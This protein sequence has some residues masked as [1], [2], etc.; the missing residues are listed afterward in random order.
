[1][2][3]SRPGVGL[4]VG[5]DLHSRAGVGL[6][7]GAALHSRAGVGLHAGADRHSRVPVALRAA[8]DWLPHGL[9]KKMFARFE[10]RAYGRVWILGAHSSAPLHPQVLPEGVCPMSRTRPNN[11]AE[12]ATCIA[13]LAPLIGDLSQPAPLSALLEFDF[14]PC[15]DGFLA[16]SKRK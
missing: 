2:A 1:G 4:R 6:R 3:H 5:V 14:V 7:V 10:Y 16:A 9:V 8:G 13:A 11:D 15:R 12:R